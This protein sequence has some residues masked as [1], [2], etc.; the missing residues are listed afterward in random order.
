MTTEAKLSLVELSARLRQ[1]ETWPEGFVWNY[2]YC[3]SC[4]IGLAARLL[5]EVPPNYWKVAE[6]FLLRAMPETIDVD[7]PENLIRDV[8]HIFF[9][10][11]EGTTPDMVAD[12]I[13]AWLRQ[14]P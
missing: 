9:D 8:D 3:K 13:D 11:K 6:N 12:A 5:S 4:A 10:M 1:P 7:D 2:G 14:R